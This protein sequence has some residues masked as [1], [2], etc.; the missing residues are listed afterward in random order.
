M[1]SLGIFIS[2]RELEDL[3]ELSFLK[4]FKEENNVKCKLKKN[5]ECLKMYLNKFIRNCSEPN[6][7]QKLFGFSIVSYLPLIV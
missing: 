4:L 3:L 5:F 2:R 7:V 6:C 1:K